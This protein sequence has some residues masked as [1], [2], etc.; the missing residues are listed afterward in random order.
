MTGVVDAEA[1]RGTV[2]VEGAAWVNQSR[3]RRMG[4][5][6]VG[7]ASDEGAMQGLVVKPPG[8]TVE[9]PAYVLVVV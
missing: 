2:G 8:L 5:A 7:E 4:A 9:P 6:E 3:G 1:T